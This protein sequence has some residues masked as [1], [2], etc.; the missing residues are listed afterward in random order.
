[1]ST[2]YSMIAYMDIDHGH[3]RSLAVEAVNAHE[4]QADGFFGGMAEPLLGP[5]TILELLHEI[6][7]LRQELTV[8]MDMVNA[9]AS[10][11]VSR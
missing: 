3:I 1:M 5:S 2:I 6:D 10:R 9:L 4:R 7:S 11:G 8:A